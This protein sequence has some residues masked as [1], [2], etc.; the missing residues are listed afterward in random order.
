MNENQIIIGLRQ[1]QKTA[2][3]EDKFV[4]DLKTN[5][6]KTFMKKSTN[7]NWFFYGITVVGIVAGF[8]VGYVVAGPM[9]KKSPTLVQ[10]NTNNE[11]TSTPT[12]AEPTPLQI[13]ETVTSVNLFTESKNL[14]FHYTEETP[15]TFKNTYTKEYTTD[16]I[17]V[18]KAGKDIMRVMVNGMGWTQGDIPAKNVAKVST[19]YLGELY[20]W[21][22]NV[23]DSGEAWGYSAAADMKFSGKCDTSFEFTNKAPCAL[24]DYI[25]PANAPKLW[26]DITCLEKQEAICDQLVKGL[27]VK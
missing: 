2:E 14:V 4:S 11:V 7:K 6:Q 16:L 17:I 18:S 19:R 10:G 1:Q 22:I 3:P 15:Y 20:R 5:L 13:K 9:N 8:L 21:Q 12:V 24:K 26:V 25:E 23:K 27:E